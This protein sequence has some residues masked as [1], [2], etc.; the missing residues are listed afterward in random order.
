MSDE[1]ASATPTS[2]SDQTPPPPPAAS[3]STKAASSGNTT[4]S[5]EQDKA[6][7]L[8]DE[9]RAFNE[10]LWY[11]QRFLSPAMFQY[12]PSAT[13]G[14]A[15]IGE[16][17]VGDRY[18]IFVGHTVSRTPGAVRREL[19]D[20]I[21]VRYVEVA[22]HREMVETLRSRRLI[23]LR[24]QPGT[25]RVTTALQLLDYVTGGKVYRLE[26]G[27]TI[28]SLTQSGLPEKGAGYL[29]EL[30]R[31]VGGSLTE[32][33]LDKL[34]GLL[35]KESAFCVLVSESDPRHA[36][37]FGGYAFPYNPPEPDILLKRH[38]AHESLPDDADD[39]EERLEQLFGEPWISSALGPCPRPLE[40]VRMA[41]LL[42]QH[43]RDRITR[44][45]V[46]REAA[47]AVYFQVA[48]W[49]TALQ[50]MPPG[51]ELDEA[52]RLAAFRIALAVLNESPYHLVAEAAGYLGAKL[53]EA[54]G[55]DETR[56]TSLFAD[57]EDSRLPAL[58]A[59]VID[60]HATFGQAQVPM[61]LLV[62]HDARYP[63][64][65]LKYVWQTHHRMRAAIA[66]WLL[67]LGKDV[68]PMLWVRA[69]QATGY[70]CG[71]DFLYVFT[72]MI[73]PGATSDALSWS[74]S[75]RMRHSAAIA[76]DQAAQDDHLRPAIR[77]RLR[78]WRNN[79]DHAL[80]W[81]AAAAHGF[82]LGRRYLDESLNELR[83][84]GT[85]S[86]RKQT[87]DDRDDLALVGI[88]GF[89]IAKLAAFGEAEPVLDRLEQWIRSDR[90]SL[91]RLAV[92]ALAHL[93]D[94]YGFELDYLAMSVGRE[95]RPALPAGAQRWPLLLAL[96][97]QDPRLTEPIAGLLR[98]LLRVREGSWIA[99]EFL[100]KWIRSGER[101]PKFLEVLV[102]FLPYVVEQES[103]AYRLTHLV[104][105]MSKDWADPLRD[106]VVRQLDEA[107]LMARVRS[108][109]S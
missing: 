50:A 67:E 72:K 89:S 91:R 47:Q 1:P 22:G 35:E 53:I 63:I 56:R 42:A 5:K 108:A 60:G 27:E 21:R 92:F 19:L 57:D 66:W 24:G 71:L 54:T 69:A 79:E 10:A 36:D 75:K 44:E 45:D 11:G 81:T 83:I 104:D 106:E 102:D 20:W 82:A 73:V 39:F 25:G 103:D 62:F 74:V 37:F 70:L 7:P 86:E 32:A 29:G 49:F 96:Q 43:A 76:L 3:D 41:A 105:R 65:I 99:K 68:R 98:Q 94:L 61:P 46:E 85:P 78:S 95:E 9:P 13:I 18:Q 4:Q 97:A 16:M 84:L 40:S 77:E 88:S 26:S 14:R 59:K 55:A 31:R 51:G 93:I 34:R 33:H 38:L 64:A 58:R 80:R 90:S 15:D 30:S 28:K 107:I 101:D 109:V 52:L 100:G 12:G 6:N 87:M 23:L 48:E 17:Q 8:D 2:P